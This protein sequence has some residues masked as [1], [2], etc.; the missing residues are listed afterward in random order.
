MKRS[1][2]VTY[3]SSVFWVAFAHRKC[4]LGKTELKGLKLAFWLSYYTI[5]D[6]V[7]FIIKR[8]IRRME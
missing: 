4:W 2:I 6:Y 5:F 3:Y 8:K 1:D 7:P